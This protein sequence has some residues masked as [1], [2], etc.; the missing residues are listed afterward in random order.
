MSE[1]RKELI[2]IGLIASLAFMMAIFWIVRY[3]GLSMEGDATRLTLA[4]EAVQ[5]EGTITPSRWAYPNGFALPVLLGYLSQI[6]SLSIKDIQFFSPV[7]VVVIVL[8]AFLVYKQFLNNSKLGGFA[9][10]LLLI[11]PDFIF[12]IFRGSHEKTTWTLGFLILLLWVK[13]WQIKRISYQIPGVLSVYILLWGI[14]TNNA[15]FAST[16]ILMF[17]IAMVLNLLLNW[18]MARKG[19]PGGFRDS[20]RMIYILISGFLLVF[21][22]ITYVYSPAMGFY[23]TLESVVNKLA[24]LFLAGDVQSEPYS[25]VQSAWTSTGMYLALTAFQW[26]IVIVSIVGWIRD[27]LIILRKGHQ[28]LEPAKFLLWSFYF[29]ILVQL[30]AAVVLDF[31]GFLASNTQ[32]RLFTPFAIFTA[33]YAAAVF[34]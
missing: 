17:L 16:L 30:G 3:G 27:G 26:C 23:N 33:P 6:T 12:Y 11:Q 7:W 25:Y 24:T 28:S 18:Y 22:F 15:Y 13:N 1:K 14:I 9:V 34:R 20:N 5:E 21:V 8:I 4:A 19:K 29:G 31:A 2:L 32:V 10:L